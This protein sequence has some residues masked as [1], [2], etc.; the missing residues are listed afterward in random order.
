MKMSLVDLGKRLLEA[1]R[2]GEDDE[3]R[4]LMASGAPFTTDWVCRGNRRWFSVW[5]GLRVRSSALNLKDRNG[6]RS[7]KT[8]AWIGRWC[9]SG[10]LWW[11]R[12]Q[13]K[14]FKNQDLPQAKRSWCLCKVWSVPHAQEH[15]HKYR[16]VLNSNVYRGQ[17]FGKCSSTQLRQMMSQVKLEELLNLSVTGSSFKN[18][19]IG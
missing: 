11:S 16:A 1:A 17:C 2:K 6:N 3:V 4:K 5:N 19:L 18:A 10:F 7:G 8:R 9:F 13:M 14:H 15:N 12:F